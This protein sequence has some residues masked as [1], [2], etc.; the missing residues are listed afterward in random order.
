M[1]PVCVVSASV[2]P[3]N[4]CSVVLEVL[5]LPVS[6]LLSVSPTLSASSSM[7]I[8]WSWGEGFY[9]DILFTATHSNISLFEQCQAV[10]S[11]FVLI[12][13]RRKLLWFLRWWMNEALT[14]EYRWVSPALGYPRRGFKNIN[15]YDF[16]YFLFCPK[17][18]ALVGNG[19]YVCLRMTLR[20]TSKGTEV[21]LNVVG[22]FLNPM[23]DFVLK[24]WPMACGFLIMFILYY[25][26]TNLQFSCECLVKHGMLLSC[27]SCEDRQ[28]LIKE[29]SQWG[30]RLHFV[31]QTSSWL[32]VTTDLSQGTCAKGHI[33]ICVGAVG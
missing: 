6:F 18:A 20:F 12:C 17:T 21:F 19:F 4:V 27:I 25:T 30:W 9:G 28:W 33:V 14:Y 2:S 5:V 23:Q 8:P 3:Q 10:A 7:G 15:L 29:A 26:C 24:C 11:V 31:M 16:F 32:S 13:C 1:V 22:D